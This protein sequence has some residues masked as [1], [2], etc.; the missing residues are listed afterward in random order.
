MDTMVQKMVVLED[1]NVIVHYVHY[2]FLHPWR[3]WSVPF[4]VLV[5]GIRVVLK[6]FH[7]PEKGNYLQSIPES[8]CN[9]I[10]AFFLFLRKFSR[11]PNSLNTT[12]VTRFQFC[13]VHSDFQLI[14]G[15]YKIPDFI[16]ICISSWTESL[17]L[18]GLFLIESIL[19]ANA[20]NYWSNWALDVFSEFRRKEILCW[21]K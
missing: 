8:Q 12:R 10:F 13:P 1:L 16:G 14:I 4:H 5:L 2:C 19:S 11:I 15:T 20:P 17:P 21:I 3:A 9:R 18:R 6:H 7:V